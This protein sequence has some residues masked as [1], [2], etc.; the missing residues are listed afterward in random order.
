M[1]RERWSR[2]YLLILAA[3]KGHK[4]GWLYPTRTIVAVFFWAL[5]HDRAIRWACDPANWPEDLR[6]HTL[7]RP[8]RMSKRLKTEQVEA[9]IEQIEAALQRPEE[10]PVKAIDSKPLPIGVCSKDPDARWGRATRGK[11]MLGYKLFAIWGD[12]PMPVAWRITAMNV[13]DGVG[14]R[15]LLE[16]LEGDGCVTADG[17]FDQN[18]NYDIAAAHGHQLIALPRREG[19]GR[20]HR[21]Q[22]EHRLLGLELVQL[23][24]EWVDAARDAIERFFSGLTSS[25]GGLTCLPPWA[26][27]MTRVTRWVQAKLILNALRL[28]ALNRAT[29]MA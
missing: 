1:E 9:V 28:T 7:P 14:G 26:R 25:S 10:S 27:R 18:A 15:P 6:P 17:Q 19:A 24:P 29:A 4:S 8:D 13:Q 2:L 11:L 23:V 21:P 20:G 3:S 5:L 12:G 16:R 22:S